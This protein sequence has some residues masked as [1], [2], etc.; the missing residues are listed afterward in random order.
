MNRRT[1]AIGTTPSAVVSRKFLEAGVSIS[2][3]EQNATL[4]SS[5]Q[6]SGTASC[7][8]L[9]DKP[10]E[11]GTWLGDATDS[12]TAVE[13]RLGDASPFQSATP[14]GSGTTL[15]ASWTFTATVSA[16]GPL[17]ITAKVS[18]TRVTFG[19][20]VD[21]G[22]RAVIIDLGPPTLSIN[23]PADVTKAAPPYRTTLT[24]TAADG[25]GVAAVEWRLGPNGTFQAA[26][27]TT[28]WTAAVALPSL[29]THTVTLRARDNLGNVSPTKDVSVKVLDVT[30]PA[31]SIIAPTEGQTF[32]LTPN[33]VTVEV[34]GT[35]SD[36]QT[37]VALVEW[38]LG[39]QG[40]FKPATP[41]AVNDWS[42]WSMAVPISEAGSQ[43]ISIRVK[44]KAAPTANVT[45]QQR[46]VVVA[47]PFEPKDPDAVFSA[48]AYLDDLLD[49]ATRRAKTAA[50]NGTLISRQLL[51]ETFLQPF[52]D[53]VTPNHRAVA[54]RPV[55]QVRLCIEGLRRYLA[56]HGRSVSATAESAYR[57]AVYGALLRS[58]GTSYEELRLARIAD[59]GARTALADRL[60]IDLTPFRPDR[61]DQLLLQPNQLTEVALRN[62]FGLEETIVKPLGDSVL[63]QPQLLMWM[64]DHLRAVWQDQD[65]AAHSVVET[66][67]PVID[68]DLLSE[69]DF[70]TSAVGN[71]AFDVWKA[72]AQDIANRLAA[73]KKS[74]EGQPSHLAGFDRIVADTLG[75]VAALVTL[76]QQHQ[77]GTAIE[78]QLRG[79]Q[80]SLQPF[81]HLMRIRKLAEGGSVLDGEWED[82]YAIVVQVQ[83]LRLYEA[84]RRE[85]RQ[86]NLTLGPD[87]FQRSA[88]SPQ[89]SPISH[90]RTSLQAQ[91]AWRRMLEARIQQESAVTHS[92]QHAVEVAEEAVL[93]S[94]REACIAAIAPNQDATVVANRLTQ[95]LGIDCHSSGRQKTT[96]AQQGVETLQDV[97]FSLRTGR[98]KTMPPVLG[99]ANP[100]AGWVLALD[101]AKP[102][103]ESDFDE[104]WRWMGSYA[105]W[106]AAM[107]VFAYPET[108]LLPELRPA[109]AQT[110]AYKKLMKE[111]RDQSR[112]TPALA[113]SLAASYHQTV[114]SE[115][116]ATLPEKLRHG[117]LVLTDELSDTQLGDRRRFIE[118]LFSG[119]PS[120]HLAPTYV[121]EMFY[122]VPMALALQLQKAGQYLAALDWMETV[123][124]DHLA[125]NER[126]I[127][128]GLVL[129]EAM[130]S[131]YQR[132]PDNWLRVGLNPHE[133]VA[134]R[135]SAYTRFTLTALV[136]CYL[137]FADAEFT[138]D[139]SESISRARALYSTALELL[140]LPEMQF[141]SSAS[142]PY[143]FPPSPVPQ[144]LRLHAE[145]NLFKLRNGRNI[146][147]IER[148]SVLETSQPAYSNTLPDRPTDQILRPTPYRYGVLIERAK[149]LVNIAQQ[150]EAAFLASLEKRDA[151][152]YNLLKA[153]HDL[154]LA[155]A[156]VSLQG[157]RVKE[158]E[159]GIRLAELQQDRSE[160]QRDTYQGWIDAGLNQWER[161]MMENYREA[162]RVRN[163]V[164]WIDAA[165]TTAQAVMSASSGGF[166]GTGV[167]AGLA[168][169]GIV[170][171][172]SAVKAAATHTLNKAET[173]TQTNSATASFERRREEWELQRQ[174]AE[175]EVAIGSQQITL[176]Q[177]HTD[178][179]RQEESIAR[180]QR[181]QAQTTV[182]FLANKFTNVE[183]YEWMSGILSSAY[184]YFL[185]Q[186]T[187]MAQLAQHQLA[188]ERQEAPS[189]FIGADY[190]EAPG[191]NTTPAGN[192]GGKEPDRR[193]LTG[194]VRLLQDITRL[195]QFA[196]ETRKRK[197]QL[198]QTFS[199]AQ[200]FPAE[201][202]RFRETGSFPFMTSMALFDQ[203]FPGHYLRLIKRVRV[204]VI[205]L[206]PPTRGL[207]ATLIN[208]GLSR[209]VSGSDVFQT[210]VVR[211]DPELIAF[212]SPSNSTGL[213]ELEPEGELL[214]PF[215]SMGVDTSWELQLPKAANPFDFRTIADVLFTVEY[216]ALQSLTYRQQ[217]IQ[218]LGDT[219]SSERALSLRD[220]FAD[221]WYAL[222]NPRRVNDPLKIRFT[223]SRGDFPPNLEDLR[224]QHLLLVVARVSGK[225]FEIGGSRLVMTVQGD[226]VPVGGEAGG[227]LDGIVST[228]RSNAG[229]WMGLIGKSPIGSW[230]L[231]LP[232]TQEMR[233]HIK[234]GDLDDLVLVLTYASRT[235]AWP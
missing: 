18:A 101:P 83:K 115:L 66:P 213:L 172:L 181:D 158:A 116:A 20:D 50:T 211:R 174:L 74:R 104:E 225:T 130:V 223:I 40:P 121:Q 4:G 191:D 89:P 212:T 120:P 21:T 133:I 9:E 55:P 144:A 53:L 47:A 87:E 190:W 203:G 67:Q 37:D 85:E 28:Q 185:Q 161:G 102:Y 194:S 221:E 77:H 233:K 234:D 197:L 39:N 86:K 35:A 12:I 186:A 175:H 113:R 146:A 162:G 93:P 2:S 131:R 149:N 38:A 209:V 70:R 32:T 156:T 230:E 14:T 59:P 119:I 132:N 10:G 179:T 29:G 229:G 84:W 99:T 129:E 82:V 155:A 167:G 222:H 195:D 111:L 13:V 108:Y 143:P 135:A 192:S 206:I 193:G 189:A 98:F 138:R 17:N 103:G 31:L 51:V 217:V 49:F 215:E 127:Y 112:L 75:P 26:S 142:S 205:A 218:Q 196:F 3:P 61:L 163:T 8:A 80:L 183:L 198:A 65:D 139:T 107:R 114:T 184:S 54:N 171:G 23:P 137:D 224:I 152:A 76:L 30:A 150:V 210:V 1:E 6:I 24:G 78:V 72:R 110:A 122:F 166:L 227:S 44:D 27:G 228:R 123:Y 96:R 11:P 214:L 134:V 46:G 22:S 204:S 56:R 97:L 180:N 178:I 154:Q 200:L 207:R 165:L 173:E 168:V 109:T 42:T 33:G 157:T 232:D 88:A 105:T 187:A 64:K 160:S 141:A 201:F 125:M 170:G 16:Q 202:Q 100:A 92:L 34:R 45:T 219:I 147:G 164:T 91:L 90:W 7:E 106:H 36:T 151:E 95:E 43:T 52:T 69:R 136:R 94:L 208:S 68:P 118:D 148:Q 124:T 79:Q 169:A 235:P 140:G 216:T 5:V 62:L 231:T 126:K 117:A 159:E 73:I 71:P 41:K 60:G 128:R 19:S 57:Q 220:Q 48:T 176:A 15:W 145:L 199:L 58:L 63:P 25:S 153:G 81:L 188:F 182:E 177:T 226:T